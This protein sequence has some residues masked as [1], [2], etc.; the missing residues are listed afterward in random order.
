M[1]TTD[2][3][4][5]ITCIVCGEQS[6]RLHYHVKKAHN[7][8]MLEYEML[9]PYDDQLIAEFEKAKRTN[10][11]LAEFT[12]DDVVQCQICKEFHGKIGGKHIQNHNITKKE[13]EQ[14][15]PG[16]PTICRNLRKRLSTNNVEYHIAK[17]GEEDGRRK[18]EEYKQMLADKNSF[19]Y[20]QTKHG[21]TKQQY[22]DY[23]KSR[24]QSKD[25]MIKRYGKAEGTKRWKEYVETQKIAGSSLEW[26]IDKHGD[27]EG[28]RV[29]AEINKKKAYSGTDHVSKAEMIFVTE[30]I[31]NVGFSNSTIYYGSEAQYYVIKQSHCYLYDFVV[32]EP[33]KLCIEFHGDYWHCNPIKYLPESIHSHLK[34]SAQEIWDRDKRKQ[35]AIEEQ[36]FRYHVVWERDWN[37]D[38][39]KCLT[40]IIQ[41]IQELTNE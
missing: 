31:K 15:F 11:R 27:D 25:N 41:I 1:T 18:Y 9:T 6:R 35:L 5:I 12:I 40:D 8:G 36:G 28:R 24:A 32:T 21:W 4:Q 17:H 30:L 16:A 26:F 38:K 23:N 3:Q 13:Y 14:Q 10:K 34:K 19:V 22:D 2:E 37:K 39:E 29:W 33:Y 7:M 20:K